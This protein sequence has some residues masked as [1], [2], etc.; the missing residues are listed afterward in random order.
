MFKTRMEAEPC[1][2]FEFVRGQELATCEANTGDN[3]ATTACAAC[4]NLFITHSLLVDLFEGDTSGALQAMADMAL[5]YDTYHE[6]WEA[7]S[8]TPPF[9]AFFQ[10]WMAA[11]RFRQGLQEVGKAFSDVS[12]SAG[13]GGTDITTDA[14]IRALDNILALCERASKLE[15]VCKAFGMNQAAR[16]ESSPNLLRDRKFIYEALRAYGQPPK[17]STS[18]WFT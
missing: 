6:F 12:K 14:R 5:E 10:R 9:L 11:H 16:F 1:K 18:S 7:F 15:A 4:A 3:D 2:R 17:D 13:N 8:E